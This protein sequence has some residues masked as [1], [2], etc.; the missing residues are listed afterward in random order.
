M[1]IPSY[2]LMTSASL[3]VMIGQTLGIATAPKV[4]L[5]KLGT[6]EPGIVNW[7]TTRGCD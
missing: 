7:K 1:D 5:S 3:T 6:T 4:I 2:G